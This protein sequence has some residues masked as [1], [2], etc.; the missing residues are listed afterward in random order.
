MFALVATIDGTGPLLTIETS[1]WSEG[2]VTEMEQL[3]VTFPDAE[4]VTLTP[5]V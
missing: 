2:A 5:K 3:A 4:S 1:A